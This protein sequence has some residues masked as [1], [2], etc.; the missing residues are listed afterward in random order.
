MGRPSSLEGKDALTTTVSF[1]PV[2]YKQLRLLAV[3]RETNVRELIRK[4]V[5]DYLKR[6]ARRKQS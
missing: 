1:D 2:T 3:E 4:A 6:Q 5:A